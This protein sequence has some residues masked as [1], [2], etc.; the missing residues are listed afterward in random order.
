[1]SHPPAETAVPVKQQ[2]K[3]AAEQANLTLSRICV[4]N[5][6]CDV[7]EELIDLCGWQFDN[8]SLLLFGLCFDQFL[9]V[10]SSLRSVLMR[11]RVLEQF[12]RRK[13]IFGFPVNYRF[14]LH[15][16]N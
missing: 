3:S 15:W 11:Y 12:F 14:C 13:N 16:N 4:R 8:K 9:Q 10:S 7:P 6:N 1:M 5:L 2:R